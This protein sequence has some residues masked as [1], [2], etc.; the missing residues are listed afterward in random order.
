M[1]HYR[2]PC[3]KSSLVHEIKDLINT[4]YCLNITGDSLFSKT[5]LK[6]SSVVNSKDSDRQSHAALGIISLALLNHL[7]ARRVAQCANGV[8]G[9]CIPA[10]HPRI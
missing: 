3:H 8:Y 6:G 10:L 2:A 4:V 5:V 9:P 1:A 7:N